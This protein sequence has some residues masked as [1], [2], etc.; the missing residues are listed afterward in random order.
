MALVHQRSTFPFQVSVFDFVLMGRYPYLS[1]LGNYSPADRKQADWALERMSL[2]P[3]RDRFLDEVS[4]GEL[5]RVLIARAL[6]QD[7]P[8]FLMDEPAQQLDPLYRCQLYELLADL[9]KEGRQIV[10]TSHDRE[11]VEQT[12]AHIIGLRD[13]AVTYNTAKG[14]WKEAW[15]AVY[16]EG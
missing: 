8:W 6:C 9:A 3:F 14:N 10:C 7:A 15:D 16:A 2:E 13:G 1:L 11:A 12:G 5:Q 4:G